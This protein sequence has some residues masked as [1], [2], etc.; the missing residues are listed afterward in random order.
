MKDEYTRWVG[1]D[2]VCKFCDGDRVKYNFK[3]L[4]ESHLKDLHDLFDIIVSLNLFLI[5]SQNLG[6]ILK[7]SQENTYKVYRW[8]FNW[9]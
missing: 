6:N 4:P 1:A 2:S 9:R 3:D 8:T 7:L 5:L